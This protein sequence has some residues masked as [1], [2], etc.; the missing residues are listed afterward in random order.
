V[1]IETA[2][3]ELMPCYYEML[4]TKPLE[5]LERIGHICYK[6]TKEVTRESA[7]KFIRQ[8][9]A[10]GHESVLE[11]VSFSVKFICDRGVSHEMVRHR[12][13]SFTQESTRYAN[14]S[15]GR[16]GSEITVIDPLFFEADSPEYKL[17]CESCEHAETAYMDLLERGCTPQE[18]RSV[19]PNSLKTEIVVTANLREWRKILGLR[20]AGD[21]HPQI[22]EIMCPLCDQLK[23][24]MPGVFDDITTIYPK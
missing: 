12:I 19:L 3:F 9:I 23:L 16:F 1:K 2:S 22:R 24:D 4:K 11:H 17:W 7:E 8:L 14:Y 5:K 13:A 6:S 15:K 21:A 20:C 10:R 18:A